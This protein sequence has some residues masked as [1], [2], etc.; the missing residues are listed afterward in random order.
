[1]RSAHAIRAARALIVELDAHALRDGDPAA[2]VIVDHFPSD[3][4][5]REAHE[6]ETWELYRAH[7]GLPPL[8]VP[9]HVARLAPPRAAL[10]CA[11]VLDR[12]AE[13]LDTMPWDVATAFPRPGAEPADGIPE[14]MLE[15]V[16]T[17]LVVQDADGA[18]WRAGRATA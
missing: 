16:R 5:L 18:L 13:S 7:A 11:L 10:V 15:A 9:E 1:M 3:E 12:S 4:E 14:A 6:A 8:P 17:G 2:G